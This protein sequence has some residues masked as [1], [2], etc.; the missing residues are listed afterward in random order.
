MNNDTRNRI[1]PGYPARYMRSIV[2]VCFS[3][4]QVLIPAVALA[5]VGLPP[6]AVHQTT[7]NGFPS[8]QALKNQ[9]Y[10]PSKGVLK[11]QENN[12]GS[13]QVTKSGDT[14]TGQ[15]QKNV[16][17]TGRYGEKATAQ[18]AVTQRVSSSKIQT[19][20]SAAYLTASAGSAVKQYGELLGTQIKNAEYEKAV[21]TALN[22]ATAAV[23][24][25]TGGLLTGAKSFTDSLGLTEAGKSNY[26][27]SQAELAEIA[28]KAQTA[29]AQAERNGD[30]AGA[31]ANAA[32]AKAAQAAAKAAEAAKIPTAAAKTLADASRESDGTYSQLYLRRIDIGSTSNIKPKPNIEGYAYQIDRHNGV[33]NW[34][35][36]SDSYF[37][38]RFPGLVLPEGYGKAIGVAYWPITTQAEYEAA[39]QKVNAP[40]G[41]AQEQLA[42]DMTLNQSDIEAILKKMLDSQQTNHK[43]LM[44][45][46]AKIEGAVSS[47]TESTEYA[48]VTALSEPYTPAGSN[49]AQ[50]TQFMIDKNGNVSSITILRPDLTP[51][52]SQ[53]P[54]R[55]SIM[56][57][58]KTGTTTTPSESTTTGEIGTNTGT[59]TGTNTGTM[60]GTQT[61]QQDI[62]AKHPNS[63]AC[64]EL[65]NTD[66]EDI[67]I[68]E[69]TLDL[70]FKPL[71]H[72][73]T[74]GTCP[75]PVVYSLGA[76]G[77][78]EFSYEY[79]CSV[80][81]LIRP[82]LIMGTM[83]TC[84]YMIYA[85]MRDL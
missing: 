11:V 22:M 54:I 48:Q 12:R 45:Q 14:I 9:G 59:S 24:N 50:Q 57:T 66:Y 26:D 19:A 47:A 64:A 40:K 77:T 62:C 74:D 33:L 76:L 61:Q 78:F 44:N 84:G 4:Q 83:I 2:L 31:V 71:D 68:P 25:L 80:A 20:A 69:E 3:A 51:N 17:V 63:A 28:K 32:T 49:T 10:D 53:A 42:K 73:S 5:D 13:A 43:E 34:A 16:T 7:E 65:G 56:P 30:F 52:S 75:A 60:A 39:L 82:I 27:K 36:Q 46:L 58:N 72:F 29:Q 70:S 67:K 85:T 8:S 79:I 41:E 35:S 21:G 15:Q 38:T 1:Y 23:D 6:P 81:R 55:R 37:Q 18:T